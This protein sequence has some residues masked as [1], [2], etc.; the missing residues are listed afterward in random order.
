[1]HDDAR[2]T[3]D[4]A[5]LRYTVRP[6]HLDEHLRLLADVDAE[7]HRRRPPRFEWTTYRIV[8]TRDFVEI[9]AGH[10][11]PGPLPTL[12]A[13]Q[14]YRSGLDARCETRKFDDLAVVGAFA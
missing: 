13:F 1:M 14:R 6:E 4:T 8:G 11:L 5:V 9:V 3:A 12:P 2:A 7:L 10:P